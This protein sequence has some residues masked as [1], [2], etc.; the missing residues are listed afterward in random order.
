MAALPRLCQLQATPA[1]LQ[2]AWRTIPA[3]G[4]QAHLNL[5]WLRA[6]MADLPLADEPQ[7]LGRRAAAP[8]ASAPITA[9]DFERTPTAAAAAL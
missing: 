6:P 7:N 9:R 1:L 2:A 3:L 4:T 8:D 5:H